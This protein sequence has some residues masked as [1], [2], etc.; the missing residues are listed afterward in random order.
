IAANPGSFLHFIPQILHGFT[1]GSIR[2]LIFGI[3][4]VAVMI[5]RPEGMIPSTRRRRELHHAESE[6][7]EEGSLDVPPGTAEFES[8]VRVE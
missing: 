5:F 1:F 7:S 2:N 8:E 6:A 3:I 4:L